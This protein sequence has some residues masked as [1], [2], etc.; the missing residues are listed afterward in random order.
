[1]DE[2]IKV[3]DIMKKIRTEIDENKKNQSKLTVE[4]LIT[5][6]SNGVQERMK[7]ILLE[8]SK[9]S[10]ELKHLQSLD[11][12]EEPQLDFS[13][14]SK[15]EQE[16]QKANE[17]VSIQTYNEINTSKSALI[18]NLVLKI[19]K[20]LQEEIR[21]TLNP[22]VDKQTQFNTHAVRVL[23]EMNQKQNEMNQKEN[24]MNQK[25]NEMNQ[26]QNEMNQ[27]QK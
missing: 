15:L 10:K 6:A 8:N 11:L 16:L 4:N 2:T 22:I 1:L 17:S 14:Q 24:E 20:I 25:E 19:R 13:N 26:K 27:K 18:R 21:F 7:K 5:F 9:R 23:N 3:L 12:N